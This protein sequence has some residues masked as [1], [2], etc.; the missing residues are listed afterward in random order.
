VLDAAAA[1]ELVPEGATEV[2]TDDYRLVRNADWVLGPAFGAAQ[3][4]W[5]RTTRPRDEVIDEVAA[6]VRDWG[7][8]GVAWWVTAASQPTGIAEALRARGA[9]LIDA[10]QVLARELGDDLPGLAR[11]AAPDRVEVHGVFQAPTYGGPWLKG[12][13]P[14]PPGALPVQE[15]APVVPGCA[16]PGLRLEF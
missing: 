12:I 15:H 4:T 3:V 6:R 16:Y 10:V 13:L 8:P 9:E 7:L 14:G 1:I 5:S 11:Q 2:R